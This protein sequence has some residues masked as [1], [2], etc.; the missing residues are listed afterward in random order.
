MEEET[1]TRKQG[2]ALVASSKLFQRFQAAGW[3]VVT[4]RGGPRLPTLFSKSSVW[5][6]FLRVLAG[7]DPPLLPSELKAKQK[8]KI[9]T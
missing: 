4:R 2:F 8:Q 5:A 3:I 6:A 7:E 9:K 1:I